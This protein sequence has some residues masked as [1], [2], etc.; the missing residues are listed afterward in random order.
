LPLRFRIVL[1][2]LALLCL[3]LLAVRGAAPLARDSRAA[4]VSHA[5][6]IAGCADDDVCVFAQ[7]HLSGLYAIFADCGSHTVSELL[8]TDGLSWVNNSAHRVVITGESGPLLTAD[9]GTWGETVDSPIAS[10]DI[11]C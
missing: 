9:P 4:V 10:I 5:A 3:C 6:G 8:G 2:A 7:A 1:T 11:R